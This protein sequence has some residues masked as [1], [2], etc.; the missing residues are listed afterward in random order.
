MRFLLY[1][2]G[3]TNVWQDMEPAGDVSEFPICNVS[4]R[5]AGSY[6][7]RYS[8]KS[9]PPMWS[10][11]SDPME[12]PS[13]PKPNISLRPSARV[14]P[15]GDVTI[16]PS[17]SVSP[18][19]VIAPG[20]AVTIRCQCRCE[21]RRLFLYKDGIKIR[22]LNAAGDGGEFT[23]LSARW[24]DSGSFSCRSRSRLEPP[25]WSDLSDY[26][27]IVV[28]ET[29]YPK[30]SISL[31]PS[32]GL[33]LRGAVTVRCR[34]WHQNVRFL[35]YK[36]GNQNALQD[37]EPDGDVAEFPIRNMSWRIAGNY[38]CRYSTK[39]DRP[40]C[41]E[42]SDPVELVVAELSYPKPSISLR[43]SGVVALG[44]T[45]TIRCRGLYQNVRFLLYKDGNPNTLQ[46][47]ELA[48]DLAEFPIRN[49][50]RRHAGSYSCYYHDKWYPFI[51]SHPSDP[52]ELVVAVAP[53]GCP[54][55]IHT[56]ITHLVLG[57]VVLLVLELILAETY[58][59]HPREAP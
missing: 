40:I 7:C 3:N 1:Y 32:R 56:N 55:F 25:N 39:S 48:G 35:L 20:R 23:I 54:D 6:H 4:W 21:A 18:S 11:P 26:V 22:E 38:S 33:G 51:W 57:A 17:I 37:V 16:R 31:R 53:S 49:V 46:D 52:V 19:G 2:V 14:A 45:V 58:Y 59:S 41:S 43:P 8:T 42:P 28:A 13:Y 10:E 15:G 44:G 27:R 30:P 12:P 36:D 24:E 50:S 9:D 34:G 29:Y 47:V 5:D